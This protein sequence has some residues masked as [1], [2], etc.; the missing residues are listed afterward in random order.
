ME[1]NRRKTKMTTEPIRIAQMMTDMNYGGV[2][3]VVMN[4]YRNIDKTKVQFD[5][6]ALEGSTIPQKEE[7]ESLGG[8]VFVVPKYTHLI[9]YE[10][11]V[12]K[13][14]KENKYK[15]VHSHMNTLSVFSLFGAKIAGVPNRIL[16]NHSTAG[17][18]ETK[19]NFMKYAL[20][21]FAK[22]F[23]TGLCACSKLAGNWIY[24]KG[25]KFKVF[26]NAI[27]L[28]MY[29]YDEK[30][31]E[32]LRAE[33]GLEEK[34]VIGHIGRFCYQKNHDLLIDIFNEVLKV[35]KDASLMLIGEG[36]LEQEVKDKVKKLGI[37]DKVLFLGRRADAYRYYQAMDL[38]LLPSRY[39]GLPV[40]GVEAQACGLPCVFSDCVTEEAKLLNSTVYVSGGIGEYVEKVVE[41]LK[42]KRKDTSKEMREAGYDIKEEA[43]KLLEF[44]EGLI[45]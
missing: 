13:L 29:K 16:H 14:F 34:K 8:R 31:R 15:I 38:F 42:V 45:K 17:K 41:G 12:I 18:G 27:D 37:E 39:E 33:L 7:I 26:N 5:F 35:E 30:K 36:E 20:R 6:F 22:L 25:T 32:S 1:N 21:P 2:E 40:V 44:Y 28:D 24:G 43:G 9:L 11:A 3:M 19:K 23:P 10:K 4:Y